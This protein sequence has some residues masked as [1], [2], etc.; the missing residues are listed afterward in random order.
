MSGENTS[1]SLKICHV[2]T[3]GDHL[4]VYDGGSMCG[5]KLNGKAIVVM[6]CFRFGPTLP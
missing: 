3:A 1:D 6:V 2:E 5:T 4:V